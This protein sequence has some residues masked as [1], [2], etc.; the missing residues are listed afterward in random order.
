MA[1]YG[2]ENVPTPIEI[3]AELKSLQ[4]WWLARRH[5]KDRRSGRPRRSASQID[6]I[7]QRTPIL[8]KVERIGRT[9]REQLFRFLWRV[10]PWSNAGTAVSA[11]TSKLTEPYEMLAFS[12]KEQT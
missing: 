3:I 8:S 5:R 10:K 4:N 12:T 7:A 6:A 11:G 9:Y 1:R 2:L